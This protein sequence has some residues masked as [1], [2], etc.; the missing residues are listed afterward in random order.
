MF[1]LQ[2]QAVHSSCT[3]DPEDDGTKILR[4]VGNNLPNITLTSHKTRIS[5]NTTRKASNPAFRMLSSV[6]TNQL[7]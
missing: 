1:H 5:G 6:L 4:K 2:D 7:N 3:A